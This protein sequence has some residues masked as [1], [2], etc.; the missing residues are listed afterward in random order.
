MLGST[1]TTLY[2]GSTKSRAVLQ[3]PKERSMTTLNSSTPFPSF[4]VDDVEQSTGL[5]RVLDEQGEPIK[6]S[7]VDGETGVSDEAA[8]R[9]WKTMVR[10]RTVDERMLALQRQGRIG[11][12]GAATGQEAGVIGAAEALSPDD[13]IHPALRE[14]GMALHRGFSL[15]TWLAHCFGNEEDTCTKG[16]QMPCHYGSRE[17]N[18][19]TL[20]SVMTTQFPQAVGTAYAMALRHRGQAD[21]P[22]CFAAIGDGATSEGDFHVAMNFAGVMRPD[23]KGL[24]LVLFCQNNQWAISTPFEKQCAA[25]SLAIKAIGYGLVGVRVDG[26]DALAVARVVT[27][28]AAQARAGAPQCSSRR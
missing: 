26:N 14:G 9:M 7:L 23:G 24:P 28:A 21:R 10:V 15:R 18:Y 3:R 20:S 12:Y 25:P 1:A 6:S 27:A 22:L 17:H 2:A 19:I 4:A 8:L 11:F 16:R 13:W 5:F